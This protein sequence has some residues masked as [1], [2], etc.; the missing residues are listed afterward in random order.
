MTDITL[1]GLKSCD[2]CR[3]ALKALEA[4]GKSA[5]FVDVRE[6]ADLDARLPAWLE[7]V[8]ADTLVNTRSTTWRGLSDAER[9]RK[10]SA[11]AS[12][13]C[14]HP[15]LIKRPVIEAGGA[16]H[17]GWTKPTQAALGL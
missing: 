7:A 3:K 13:L 9:S 17:V 10:D 5:R 12:L 4:A 1:H 16:V 2:T 14:D 6:V 15:A 11:P 8:G